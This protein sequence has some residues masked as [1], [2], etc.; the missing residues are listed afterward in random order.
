MDQRN[1]IKMLGVRID[2]IDS[3][4]LPD[5]FEKWLCDDGAMRHVVTVNPEYIMEAQKNT[6]FREC[7][8]ASVLALADG[9]GLLY[10]AKYRYG[11]SLHRITGVDAALALA[12]TCAQTGKSIYLL[13]AAQGVAQRAAQDLVQR[14]PSLHI[15]GV[16]QGPIVDSAKLDKEVCERIV[17]SRADALLVA[18]GSP[19]QD[20][21][22][23]RHS[24]LL[25]GVKIAM[26][27]GGTFDYLAGVVPRAPSF[28]RLLGLEWL[29]R[30]VRQP[31]RWRRIAT[32]V[33][34]FPLAVL[35]SKKGA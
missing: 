12:D 32:A 2:A 30:L 35:F 5:V 6:P 25:W 31:W 3:S 7:L 24:S 26:G 20:L 28:V 33:V 8:N 9:V 27:V 17:K 13:G 16:E 29:Y 1:T 23:R 10:A 14:Y 18:F 15:A 19:A 21:W 22:I 4:S 34:L 11:R